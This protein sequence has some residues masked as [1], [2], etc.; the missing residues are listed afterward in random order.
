MLSLDEIIIY[1]SII[2]WGIYGILVVPYLG[3]KILMKTGE[4]ER[5]WFFLLVILNLW[6]LLFILLRPSFRDGLSN[7]DVKKLIILAS[8]YVVF[9]PILVY[10]LNN[11]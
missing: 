7:S 11:V 9:F 5:Y 10:V 4:S 3:S 6:A 2:G 1:G 8:G